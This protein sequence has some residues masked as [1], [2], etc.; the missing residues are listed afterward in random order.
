MKNYMNFTGKVALITGAG[1]KRGIGV[2]TARMLAGY[3]CDVVLADIDEAGASENAQQITKETG[4]RAVAVKVD[5]TQETS[6]KAMTERVLED[7]GKIDIL[8]NNAGISVPNA[9]T[10][11]SLEEWNHVLAI[12]LTSAFLC[13]REIIPHMQKQKYGRVINISSV[14]GKNGGVL[15]GVHYTTTKGAMVSMS[16]CIAKQVALDG[17]TVN[18]V[19]PGTVKTDGA[20]IPWEE[21]KPS[22][23]SMQRR[24]ETEE[25]AGAIVYL[26]SEIAGYNTGSTIDVNGGLYMD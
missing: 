8:V 25:I 15:G 11:V 16:K 19:A 2:A 26:A 9:F 5:L 12:N 22:Q 10:D 20:G 24:A 14:S 17:V 18:C 23:S 3:G 6:I 1:S 21:K 7:F 13:C 4:V